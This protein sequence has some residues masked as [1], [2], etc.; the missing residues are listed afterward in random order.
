MASTL[1]Q[2]LQLKPGQRMAILHCPPEV[3]PTLVSSL[4]GI[5]LAD[6]QAEA[7]AV[8]IFVTALAD[9]LPRLQAG[10]SRVGSTGLVWMVY[11]KGTSGVKTDVNRDKIWQASVPSNWRPIRM[12]ALDETWSCMRFRPVSE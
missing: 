8:L 1:I 7:D 6:E 11:P 12:I 2:K 5:T 3:H 4:P 10:I 9:V